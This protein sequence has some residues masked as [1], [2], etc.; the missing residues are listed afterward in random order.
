ME[1]DELKLFVKDQLALSEA[2]LI[3]LKKSRNVHYDENDP[4]ALRERIRVF[5]QI[6]DLLEQK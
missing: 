5:E 6:I 4:T 1:I 3:T 2:K